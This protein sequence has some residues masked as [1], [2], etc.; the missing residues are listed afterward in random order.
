M[1]GWLSRQGASP[2]VQGS[3]GLRPGPRLGRRPPGAASRPQS[4]VTQTKAL[5]FPAGSGAPMLLGEGR[6]PDFP[7]LIKD[8]Q[9]A[10]V[11]GVVPFGGDRL[12]PQGSQPTQA[13]IQAPTLLLPL[14]KRREL[15]L[16]FSQRRRSPHPRKSNNSEPVWLKASQK[17]QQR[18]P[19]QKKLSLVAL[20]VDNPGFFGR[21][22][23]TA[24]GCWSVPSENHHPPPQEGRFRL[25]QGP[26]VPLR[27]WERLIKAPW[28]GS[29]CGKGKGPSSSWGWIL[30]PEAGPRGQA[31]SVGQR[32]ICSP[33]QP[34][35]Q[36]V[37][38]VGGSR[39]PLC[40]SALPAVEAVPIWFPPQPW[41]GLALQG[42]ATLEEGERGRGEGDGLHPLGDTAL[43]GAPPPARGGIS[44][45]PTPG[46]IFLSV[47]HPLVPSPPPAEKRIFAR[48]ELHPA[49][50]DTCTDP[51]SDCRSSPS[52]VA[53]SGMLGVA[54]LGGGR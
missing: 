50:P 19:L 33:I 40:F 3:S 37:C 32:G 45:L 35:R 17:P 44:S 53:A 4:R 30:P 39:C 14:P 47:W 51:A 23:D 7:P 52:G 54:F 46:Q 25:L 43:S 18:T 8:G 10:G 6:T 26:E 1:G 42:K 15:R 12:L 34:P 24:A 36:G 5:L 13:T 11:G 16:F 41:P 28:Q 31:G 29:C 49:L 9:K 48:G 20:F 27:S 2:S 22:Q 21:P 38:A